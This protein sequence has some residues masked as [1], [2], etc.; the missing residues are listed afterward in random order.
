MKTIVVDVWDSP[1]SA[2]HLARLVLPLEDA[3]VAARVELMAGNLVNLRIETGWGS[4][5]DFDHR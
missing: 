2:E 5:Y 3:L 1:K 4:E